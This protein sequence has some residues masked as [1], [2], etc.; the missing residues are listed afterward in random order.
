MEKKKVD[1]GAVAGYLKEARVN[2]LWFYTER[3]CENW[4]YYEV[5]DG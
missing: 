4:F 2:E 3:I 1:L 5:H